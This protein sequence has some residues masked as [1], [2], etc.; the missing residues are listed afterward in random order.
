MLYTRGG[1][2]L[3]G[4]PN[5]GFLKRN[6]RGQD[7]PSY[8][9]PIDGALPGEVGLPNRPKLTWPSFGAKNTR[10]FSFS[11]MWRVAADGRRQ[12]GENVE[13][14]MGGVSIS[15]GAVAG[16]ARGDAVS[17][18]LE[19]ITFSVMAGP[20]PDHSFM[21]QALTDIQ[22]GLKHCR[23]ETSPLSRMTQPTVRRRRVVAT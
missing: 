22:T 5:V 16:S 17:W 18:N 7:S 21:T 11:L 4:T 14:A 10:P 3:M 15:L 19:G 9:V 23:A 13:I 8:L 1:R 6:L 2:T 20:R 12:R